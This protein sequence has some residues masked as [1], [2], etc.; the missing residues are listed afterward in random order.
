[1]NLITMEQARRQLQIIGTE[2]DQ[3]LED[4]RARASDIILDYLTHDGRVE[5]VDYTSL[6]IDS[7]GEPVGVPG[8]VVQ[9]TCLVLGHIFYDR[10]GQEDPISEAVKSLLNRIRLPTMY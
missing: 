5:Q 4:L 6:W 8:R 7:Q 1:M 2:R 9:A 10:E 3:E